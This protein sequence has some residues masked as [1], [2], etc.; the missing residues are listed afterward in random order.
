MPGG[1]RTGPIGMGP[2]TG[3]AAGYCAG[4]QIPGY[5]NP[6]PGRSWFGFGRGWGRGRGHGWRYW[7]W[8][9]RLPGWRRDYVDPRM[10]YNVTDITQEEET[11]ILKA[12]ADVLRKQL[13]DIENSIEILE[14]ANTDEKANK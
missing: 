12:Q 10:Y 8:S 11:S 4:Y 14:R 9:T 13:K 5:A 1:N 2:M 6:V 3:R 7:Y